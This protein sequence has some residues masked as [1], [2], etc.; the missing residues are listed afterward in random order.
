VCTNELP[1]YVETC[2]QLVV[3]KSEISRTMSVMIEPPSSG[4]G[5]KVIVIL[6]A[7]DCKY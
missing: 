6:F 7:V 2:I 3:K 5:V 1:S 4:L